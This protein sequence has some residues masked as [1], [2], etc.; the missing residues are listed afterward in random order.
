MR[1]ILNNSTSE[2][3]Q[4]G[5]R[6]KGRLRMRNRRWSLDKNTREETVSHQKVLLYEQALADNVA[7]SRPSIFNS[8]SDR[9][10]HPG[11]GP[12]NV[13][14]KAK[15]A[16]SSH[17]FFDAKDPIGIQDEEALTKS[18]FTDPSE[19]KNLDS[20]CFLLKQAENTKLHLLPPKA[21]RES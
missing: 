13:D 7:R 21:G 16:H 14:P 5:H 12:S 19:A 4:S 3:R 1:P 15:A 8:S 2:H 9:H 20:F 18:F 11:Y 17:I 10:K 6:A